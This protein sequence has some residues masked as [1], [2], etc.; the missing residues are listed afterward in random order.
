[1]SAGYD[2]RIPINLDVE[3]GKTY[4]VRT[5]VFLEDGDFATFGGQEMPF[6]MVL[7]PRSGL[8]IKKGFRLT[9]TVGIIDQD[10]RNEI[11]VSFSMTEDHHFNAND[12]FVQALILPAGIL[13]GE[14]AP[15]EERKGGFGS[16]GN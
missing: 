15:E 1:M 6:V 13:S 9:N 3:A 10:F 12:K 2:I 7:A 8:G 16:T 11:E 5:G 14:I 4:K